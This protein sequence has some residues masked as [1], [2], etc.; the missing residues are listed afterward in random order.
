VKY[1][2]N[3]FVIYHYQIIWPLDGLEIYQKTYV[4]YV[5]NTTINED[6]FFYKPTKR[7]AT[8]KELFKIV[9]DF[10]KEKSKKMVRLCWSMHG[11]ISHN[12]GK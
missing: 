1:V 4:R 11:F 2:L 9:D 6:I 7:R 3:S 5:E 10:M 8:G 12:G